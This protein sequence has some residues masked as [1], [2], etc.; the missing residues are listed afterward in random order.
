MQSRK[1]KQEEETRTATVANSEAIS[2]G[3]GTF[4]P[5]P[6]AE[7]IK[8]DIGA[9]T[10]DTGLYDEMIKLNSPDV[11]AIW[12][13][14]DTNL[15]DKDP[16]KGKTMGLAIYDSYAFTRS[17]TFGWDWEYHAKLFYDRLNALGL[18]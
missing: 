17:F 1:K 6:F 15:K 11:R 2:Q 3:A 16:E 14:Y 9:Y 7:R 12:Q 4:N 8:S 18:P 13:Y 5:K 10:A